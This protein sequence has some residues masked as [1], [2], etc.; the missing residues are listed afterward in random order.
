MPG[1]NKSERTS[2]SGGGKKERSGMSKALTVPERYPEHFI[3]I[4]RAPERAI[5]FVDSETHALKEDTA[6]LMV[7]DRLLVRKLPQITKTHGGLVLPDLGKSE[8]AYGVVV[9][10]GQGRYNIAGQLI[11]LRVMAGAVVCMGKYAGT[12]CAVLGFG[13]QEGECVVV[14]EEEIFF[15]L[16]DRATAAEVA[17]KGNPKISPVAPVDAARSV[18]TK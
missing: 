5:A 11:P 9:A 13:N 1:K 3:D 4:A 18:E 2:A 12:S 7:G 15:V 10:A 8:A 17:A 16:A 6:V 14:R